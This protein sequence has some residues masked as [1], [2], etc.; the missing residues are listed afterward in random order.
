MGAVVDEGHA[1]Q[2][3]GPLPLLLSQEPTLTTVTGNLEGVPEEEGESESV[4]DGS[5][6]PEL[7]SDSDFDQES[8]D[9]EP[10]GSSLMP[11]LVA[12]DDSGDDSDV[13]NTEESSNSSLAPVLR[14][15][16]SFV[17]GMLNREPVLCA[18]MLNS[19]PPRGVQHQPM[20][21]LGKRIIS[22]LDVLSGYWSAPMLLE[23]RER[24]AMSTPAG[25]WQM[26]CDAYGFNEL[27]TAIPAH[28]G[29]CVAR[30][31]FRTRIYRRVLRV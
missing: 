6:T 16:Q 20:A 25:H 7:V 24:T 21:R 8:D 12:R 10:D 15:S 2:E 26:K 11:D 5:D 29:S 14:G 9:D 1:P 22:V 18:G 28:A 4:L 27:R 3:A 17:H 30:H 31:A 13:E 19:S 23:H